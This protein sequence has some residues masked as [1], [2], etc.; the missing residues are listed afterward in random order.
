[1]IERF[2]AWQGCFGYVAIGGGILMF[3]TRRS[4]KGEAVA[5]NEF[6]RRA[7]RIIPFAEMFFAASHWS[8]GKMKIAAAVWGTG[9]LCC[10]PFSL[11]K[12]QSYE[13][14]H[15]LRQSGEGEKPAGLEA[16]LAA[17]DGGEAIRL[18]QRETRLAALHSR[19]LGWFQAM[20]AHR[21]ALAGAAP[22]EI[23]A[24]NAEAA[25]YAELIKLA[26]DEDA[27]IAAAKTALARTAPAPGSPGK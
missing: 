20:S 10:V 27:G 6:W 8:R 11:M 24:F 7:F 21:A 16:M 5:T 2:L 18:W 13:Q 23:V 26:S 25:A 1:M 12:L 9:F 14:K 22:A 3:F 17:G 4:V 15:A 19:L